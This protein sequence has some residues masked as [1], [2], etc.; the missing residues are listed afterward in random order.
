MP[1]TIATDVAH[2]RTRQP[3]V[4]DERE[5]TRDAIEV[6]RIPLLPLLPLLPT[7]STSPW[8]TSAAYITSPI[9]SLSHRV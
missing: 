5:K 8:L 2:V 7:C 6:F 4:P 9:G 3:D 1:R